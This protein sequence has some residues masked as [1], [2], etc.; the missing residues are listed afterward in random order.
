MGSGKSSL[1][2]YLGSTF[3]GI[4]T[5]D[6]DKLAFKNYDLNPWS[7]K[8][9]RQ[10]FGPASVHYDPVVPSHIRSVNRA[11]LSREAFK[12]QESLTALKS[13][14]SP[15]IK[16]LLLEKCAEIEY[17]KN[18]GL[19]DFKDFELIAVEGAVLIESDAAHF[20]DEL[21]V[22][23]IDREVAFQRIQ[24]RNPNLSDEEIRARLSHQT[25]D[26]ERLKHA[27]WSYDTST[28]TIEDNQNQIKQK[29]MSLRDQVGLR[30]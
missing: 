28:A 15:C 23:T 25:T 8:N 24:K 22:V 13:I 1:L 7:L 27:S 12:S 10:S 19:P 3:P 18:R 6:L 11:E 9:I 14:T 2:Q 16:K 29:V 17:K 30:I 21:W 26:Q 4:Y 5:I 20:F